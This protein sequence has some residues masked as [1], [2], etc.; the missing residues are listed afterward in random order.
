LIPA[1]AL[2]LVAAR[3]ADDPKHENH[4]RTDGSVPSATGVSLSLTNAEA[5]QDFVAVDGKLANTGANTILVLKKGE[6]S[7]V[8]PQGTFSTKAGGLF[9]ST[10]WV[11]P[12]E[13]RSIG[14]KAE[15]SGF[16]VDQFTLKPGGIYQASNTGTAV[17]APDFALPAS[18]N[19][20][21]AGPYSCHLDGLKK[22]T[23]ETSAKFACT[24]NG[25][26]VGIIEPRRIGLKT[27]SGK[28]YANEA[29]KNGRELLLSGETAKF[30]AVFHVTE[31]DM[32]FA[33]LTVLFRDALTE[34]ALTAVAL[35]DWKFVLDPEATAKAN[36]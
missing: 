13:S 2:V 7:F 4:F 31:V 28:E 32:Q 17:K 10:V 15:G 36:D 9:G 27:E 18:V 24:Y 16:H 20:F 14:F 34:S 23:D 19:D 26:G 11:P 3:K 6:A 33:P 1:L 12:G 29:K 22:E 35:P 5:Q 30:A 8:L 21:T 25:S